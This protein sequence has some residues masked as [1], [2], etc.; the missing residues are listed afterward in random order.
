EIRRSAGVVSGLMFHCNCENGDLAALRTIIDR[1]GVEFGDVLQR[2]EWVSLGGGI[3]FTA[4]GYPL[5]DF[6]ETLAA[7]SH[8]FGVQVYLEPGDAAVSH[9]GHLVTTVLDIVHND[10]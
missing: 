9:A 1:I 2:M 4:P 3:A 6:C 7:F 5:D 10:V 8:R